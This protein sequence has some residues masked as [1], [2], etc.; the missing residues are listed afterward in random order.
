M[1]RQD[2]ISAVQ[3][4]TRRIEPAQSGDELLGPLMNLPGVWSNE[5]RFPGRGWNMIALPFSGGPPGTAPYRLLVNQYNETLT[6]SLAD[7]G[8]PNRGLGIRPDPVNGDQTLVAL[9]YEQAISQI[10]IDD[11]PNSGLTRTVPKPIHHE[12]GLFL[13]M[14]NMVTNDLTVARLGTIPHGDSVLALGRTSK[15]E[16]PPDIPVFG[17]LPIGLGPQDEVMTPVDPANPAYLDPYKHFHHNLFEGLFD[18]VD[19]T[20]LLRDAAAALPILRTTVLDFDSTLESGGVLN[21]PFITRTANA[22]QLRSIFWIHE[23]DEK[24][25]NGETV[26]VIQYAQVVML[27]F[28]RRRDGMPGLIQW[29]HVSINTMQRTI[30]KPVPMAEIARYDQYLTTPAA[31]MKGVE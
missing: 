23:L 5:G 31:S 10:A 16:G 6:V 27:D 4:M 18:P 7:K 21:I 17:G 14:L 9:D 19:P 28:F 20:K 11:F 1:L 30:N 3:T 22:S 15:I 13:N 25:E 12:P 29:P 24:D 8:V 2:R 26:L